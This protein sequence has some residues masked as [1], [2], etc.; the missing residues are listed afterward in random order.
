MGSATRAGR[1][2]PKNMVFRVAALLLAVVFPA[3]LALVQAK[4]P[5]VPSASQGQGLPAP[6]EFRFD[7]VLDNDG[8]IRQ[9][10]VFRDGQQIQLLDSCTGQ[11]IPRQKG[12]G[13]L[14]REDFNF[15][16]YLDLAMRAATDRQRNS[17]YCVWLFDPASQ[18]FVLSEEVSRIPNPTPDPDTKTIVS[19]KNEDCAGHCYD[20]FTYS[21][22]DGHLVAVREEWESEDPTIPPTEDCRYVRA[23]KEP[24]NG[25]LVETSRDW[26]DV[27]GVQCV[28]HRL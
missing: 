11:D 10:A 24:K 20:Q 21:W 23:V 12:L 28:P 1:W 19:R 6:P 27:G 7:Y 18:R 2:H 9:V 17:T 8:K 5:S 13:E 26:V 22:I 15:D 3:T 25:R 14:A 16:G 4:G